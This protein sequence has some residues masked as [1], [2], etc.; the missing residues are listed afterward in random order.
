MKRSM[1]E[2]ARLAAELS[3]AVHKQINAGRFVLV[4][5]MFRALDGQQICPS[6]V[7]GIP[8]DGGYSVYD[9]MQLLMGFEDLMLEEYE[10]P[11]RKGQ[12]ERCVNNPFY[13]LGMELREL[14][15]GNMSQAA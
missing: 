2:V 4:V 15:I 3:A 1:E 9:S 6:C 14:S 11:T 5:G 13:R 10:T 8:H 12:I 7:W